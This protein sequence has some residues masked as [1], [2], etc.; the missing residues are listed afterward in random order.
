MCISILH[1]DISEGVG[2]STTSARTITED[3][4]LSGK[5]IVIRTLSNPGQRRFHKN[6]IDIR[7]RSGYQKTE[8]HLY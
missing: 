4:E 6:I 3:T 1:V 5:L 7:N 8:K 2:R